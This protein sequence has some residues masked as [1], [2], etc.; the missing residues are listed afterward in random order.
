MTKDSK[1]RAAHSRKVLRLKTKVEKRIKE[2]RI[3]R[4]TLRD[5]ASIAFMTENCDRQYRILKLAAN[6]LDGVAEFLG[7]AL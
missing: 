2:I 6:M 1:R 3:L 7:E 4:N 5:D